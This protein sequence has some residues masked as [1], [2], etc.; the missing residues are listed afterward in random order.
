MA[1]GVKNKKQR[2][3]QKLAWLLSSWTWIG[4]IHGLDWIQSRNHVIVI[5]DVILI[6]IAELVR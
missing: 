6:V 3:K 2:I 5:F 1:S 4:F